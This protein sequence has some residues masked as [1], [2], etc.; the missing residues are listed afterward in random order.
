MVKSLRRLLQTINSVVVIEDG[1]VRMRVVVMD[2][3]VGVVVEGA[4]DLEGLAAP[5]VL[6]EC[7]SILVTPLQSYPRY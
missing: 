2:V 6:S 5:V 3:V 7:I 1:G 4:E